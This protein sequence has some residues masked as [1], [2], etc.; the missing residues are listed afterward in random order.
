LRYLLN[1]YL[2]IDVIKDISNIISIVY[3][4]FMVIF[5]NYSHEI[6]VEWLLKILRPN[7]MMPING[8]SEGSLNGNTSNS[9][10]PVP[11]GGTN[12]PSDTGE[13]STPNLLDNPIRS[14][15]PSPS[16]I[17]TRASTPPSPL[18]S[19]SPPAPFAPTTNQGLATDN[20]ELSTLDRRVDWNRPDPRNTPYGTNA[21]DYSARYAKGEPMDIAFPSRIDK[22]H[23]YAVLASTIN[24]MH[25]QTPPHP[26]PGN[27][28]LAEVM[29]ILEE[30]GNQN[31][32]NIQD[33]GKLAFGIYKQIRKIIYNEPQFH[34]FINE[35]TDRVKW[36]AIKTG[37]SSEF[38][39]YLNRD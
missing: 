13:S 8:P 30:K 25:N 24:Y 29:Q 10:N 9:D 32:I 37:S 28:S 20:Q 33:E 19:P 14:N 36:G 17:P 21:M 15:A 18:R 35:N 23:I 34:K 27:S 16:N 26:N 38:M 7:Y 5:S 4:T 2:T 22:R 3:Y 39:R 1:E 6:L 11:I 31:R 12:P